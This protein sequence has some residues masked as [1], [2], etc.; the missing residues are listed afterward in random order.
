MHDVGRVDPPARIP[1]SVEA[2][3]SILLI[4]AL[5]VTWLLLFV[6]IGLGWGRV[7]AADRR[8]RRRRTGRSERPDAP[9][10]W[11]QDWKPD[12]ETR[13]WTWLG[14][15]KI[16]AGV[17]LT[18]CP[19]AAY[20]VLSSAIGP[21]ARWVLIWAP[22]AVLGIVLIWIGVRQMGR[23]KLR[24]SYARFPF[25]VGGRVDLVLGVSDGGARF[26][27]ATFVLALL[28]EFPGRTPLVWATWSAPFEVRD[29]VLPGPGN[30]M[31]LRF[32]VPSDLRGT[33]FLAARPR[34]FALFVEAHT[35]RGKLRERFLV[36]VYDRPPAEAPRLES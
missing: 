25:F 32:E 9:W 24:L 21:D 34:C 5:I 16:V 4:P 26:T 12:G 27:Q 17:F 29:D 36:P 11:D 31:T 2:A 15:R 22:V 30:D 20:L 3:M 10:T 28:E 13:A 6:L 7:H 23:G 18:A 1:D 33:D 8:R 35:D 14:F 19:G